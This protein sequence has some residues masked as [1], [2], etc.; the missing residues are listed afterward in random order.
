MAL[1]VCGNVRRL[2]AYGAG[3]TVTVGAIDVEARLVKLTSPTPTGS[4]TISDCGV[5][6]RTK[7]S[8]NEKEERIEQNDMARN[9]PR[10]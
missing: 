2:L 4:D 7:A 5:T 3:V 6:G 8:A 9:H 10:R 1:S